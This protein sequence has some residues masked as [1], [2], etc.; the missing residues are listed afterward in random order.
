M[1][2]LSTSRQGRPTDWQSTTV[3]AA[4]GNRTL[5]L[6][7]AF[8]LLFA[9]AVTIKAAVIA[10]GVITVQGNY[11]TVQHPDGGVVASILVKNGDA[12]RKGQVLITLDDTAARAELAVVQGRLDEFT[13]QLSRLMAER[14]DKATLT[15]P[16][17]MAANAKPALTRI[18][19]TQRALFDARR[20]SQSNERRV[21]VQRITQFQDELRGL[22]AQFKARTRESQLARRELETLRPLFKK[23]YASRQRVT[24]AEREAAR[25]AGEVGRLRSDTARAAGA[26]AEARLRLAQAK[27]TI[28][29]RIADELRAVQAQMSELEERRKALATR[30][31]RTTITAPEAGFVHALAIHT[32]GGVIRPAAS[33]LQIIP[34]DKA[35]IIEARV[36]PNDIDQVR[37]GQVTTVRLTALSARRTPRLSGT[38]LNVSPAQITDEAGSYFAVQIS[39]SEKE[40][41]RIGAGQRLVPGM[42]AEV[43]IESDDRSVLSY[44]LK[45][46]TDAMFYAFRED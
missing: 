6:S 14:D 39:L 44:F 7:G 42:P 40:I 9:V 38:V 12:V 27:K 8:M 35:L 13:V 2:S 31:R 37:K 3:W 15:L 24:A 20:S 23:G 10:S 25:L 28:T 36:Q 19:A 33:I 32:V 4:I 11:R 41:A 1:F 29:E 46:L 26:I 16:A 22:E 18:I 21:L 45:P 17:S 30:L 34:R 5:I 43:F